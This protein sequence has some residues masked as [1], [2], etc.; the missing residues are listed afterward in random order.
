MRQPSAS[1]SDRRPWLR[2]VHDGC[3]QRS[4][5]I[6]KASIDA[7]AADGTA[8]T[9]KNI[10]ERSKALDPEGKGIHSNTVTTNAELYEYYKA[11]SANLPTE[12]CQATCGRSQASVTTRSSAAS[13]LTVI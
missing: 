7:L 9:L 12:K 10:H 4:I 13:S 6:G 11:H 2:E 1:P 3:K 8:V 5:E